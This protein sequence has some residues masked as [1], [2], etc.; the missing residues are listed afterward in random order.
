MCASVET[1]R[2]LPA[3][4]LI[5]RSR[6]LQYRCARSGT[7]VALN[8]FDCLDAVHGWRTSGQFKYARKIGDNYAN[9]APSPLK[10]ALNSRIHRKPTG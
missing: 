3:L 4:A 1:R 8:Q 10:A 5:A 2:Q 6:R 9:S 7:L